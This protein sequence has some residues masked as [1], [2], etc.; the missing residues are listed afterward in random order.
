LGRSGLKAPG[1]FL[2]E[3]VESQPE[4]LAK[5]LRDALPAS[6]LSRLSGRSR[7]FLVG[8]GTSHHGALVGQYL[9]RSAGVEAWAIPAFEFASYPPPF[10]DDDGLVLLSHRGSKRFSQ[11]ALDGFPAKDHWLAI[12]GGGSPLGGPGVLYTVPQE[13]SPVHTASHTGAMVRLAQ[14]AVALG[15]PSWR[16]E[17]AR[18]P[19]A[20]RATLGLRRQIAEALGGL[21]LGHVVHFVGGGPAH[22]TALEGALKLREAAYLSAEGHELESILHGPLI[23]LQAED[24]VVMVA[25]PGPSQARAAEVAAAVNEIG[26]TIVAVGASAANLDATLRL[27]TPAIHEWLAPIV[28]VVPLQWLAL[29]VSRRVGVDADSFRKEGRYAAAQTKFSL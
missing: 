17:L 13:R 29:E 9:L 2:E 16:A 4:A 21:H 20:I 24:T 12:T 19:D 26:A 1:A 27:Q 8:T 22:A 10:K 11:A 6:A 14:L 23:S 15:S 5:I 18:V 7:I 28:N 3:T 25:Q